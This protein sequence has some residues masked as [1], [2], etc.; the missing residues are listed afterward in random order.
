M[1]VCTE[2][3][4]LMKTYEDCSDDLTMDNKL[5]CDAYGCIAC[6]NVLTTNEHT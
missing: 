6:T 4:S 3:C 2:D 1:C 5:K